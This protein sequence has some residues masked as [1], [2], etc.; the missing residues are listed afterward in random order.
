MFSPD[1]AGMFKDFLITV[2]WFLYSGLFPSQLE[3]VCGVR[4]MI[5]RITALLAPFYF[6]NVGVLLAF[7]LLF[8][9][10]LVVKQSL[11]RNFFKKRAK[12][13]FLLMAMMVIYIVVI[14]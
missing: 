8:I 10:F 12:F 3:V 4:H 13:L 14:A 9:Y 7:V 5:S 6:S 2:A 1:L 11:T